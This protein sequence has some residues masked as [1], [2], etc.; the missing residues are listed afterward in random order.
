MFNNQ[1]F[2]ALQLSL[3]SPD[4]IK[5]WSYGEVTKPETINYRTLKPEK[6]GLFDERIFGPTK[7]FECYCG[8]YKRVRYKGVVCDKCGVEVTESRVRRERMGHIELASPA[9]HTWYFKRS[10]SKLSLLLDVAPKDLEAVIYF[11]QS[12]V[13]E[14]DEEKKQAVL[15]KLSADLEGKKK[16]LQKE[17][18][19][20]IQ[21]KNENLNEKIAELQKKGSGEGLELQIEHMRTDTKREVLMLRQENIKDGEK[22]EVSFSA[23]GQKIKEVKPLSLLSENDL[24]ELE[25]WEATDFFKAGMGAEVLEE[26]AKM[27][28]L[29]K[30]IKRGE[31]DLGSRSVLL[32]K[33]TLAK[34]KILQGL[35]RAK[36]NPEWMIIKV[37]PVIPP[38]L[39]P[40]VQLPGG[41]FATSDL[42]DLYRKVI[43]RNNRLKNLLRLGA[44]DVILMNEKRM[45]QEAVDALI[46]G[47]RRPVKRGRKELRSLTEMLSGK[48]GRFRQNL[49]GKRVDY[50]GRSVIVVGPEL[51]VDQ[52]GIPKEMALELAKPFVLREIILGGFAPNLK[53]AKNVLEKRGDEVWDILETVVKDRPVLLNRAPTLHKQNIQAFYPIL[54]GGSAIRLHP[55]VCNGFN[56][57]FDGDAMSVHLPLSEKAVEESKKFM[58]SPNNLLK[59][60]DS[61]PIIDMKN[62][63]TVGLYYL[64]SVD[65]TAKG[66]GHFFQ[67]FNEA[68]IAYQHQG[69]AVRAPITTIFKKE[70]IET[71]V[72]RILLNEILPEKLQFYNEAVTRDKMKMLISSCLKLYSMN[73]AVK[74]TDDLKDLG[75]TF[76]TL[77]GISFAAFDFSV[78]PE[79]DE[80]LK[81]AE[82]MLDKIESNYRRGLLTERERYSQ[83]VALWQETTSKVGEIVQGKIDAS[84]MVG[85]IVN[86]KASRANR[87]T[88]AQVGGM[89]GLM[90][91]SKNRIKETP[92]RTAEIEGSTPFEGFLAALG[93]RKGLIDTALLTA[94]AGYLTR[95]LVDVAHDVLVREVDCKTREGIVISEDKEIE[96]WSLKERI[97]GRVAAEDVVSPKKQSQVLV[98]RN[99][100][101]S[102]ELAD[103]IVKEGV[104]QVRI[105]TLLTCKTRYGV[106]ANCYGWDM[107]RRELIGIGQAVGVIA[108]QSIGEPGT[109]LTLR[110]FHAGGIAK[111]EITQGL[112]RVEELLEARI[113]KEP[114]VLSELS[115]TVE[116][117][118]SGDFRQV[119]VLAEEMVEGKK[120]SE[121]RVYSIPSQVEIRVQ[122]GDLVAAGDTLT[123]GHLDLE[124][125]SRL[126]GLLFAQAYLLKEVQSVYKGQGVTINDKHVEIIL[127]KMSS[128][129]RVIKTGDTSFMPGESADINRFEEEN[130]RV[131][132]EGKESATGHR[133]LTGIT[134]SS[135]N[136]ESWLSASSFIETANVLSAAAIDARPQTDRLL[137]LKENVI[138]G[139][140]IPTDERAILPKP[141]P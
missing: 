85:L 1:E 134:R 19:E 38:D 9:V 135:L 95:R 87:E 70:K 127:R 101:I 42:N 125:I 136:A 96:D 51:R 69:L 21:K 43:N 10:P 52:V 30:E 55:A 113:P 106:C 111:K 45:L 13:L 34:L 49:L 35:R 98:E 25:F 3:A 20:K 94:D 33:K 141:E 77:P 86:S 108:A 27:I 102:E 137:G 56:A 91:D 53:S 140:L 36:I 28:D 123:L 44:P 81:E 83:V 109:Q 4:Q 114:A 84:S 61:Q 126:K 50:S 47:S 132:K 22:L 110:T 63:L 54:I 117:V 23:I 66:A 57:D 62:E 5:K 8:K 65:K 72:G 116:I 92:I 59:L 115:G 107:A 58:L 89:R 40:M 2:N 75:R 48:H 26:A 60:A 80:L 39:R 93:G 79:R 129:I 124:E 104:K 74:L 139:R 128:R 88:L 131:K 16:E 76:A 112:P 67:N 100:L 130:D 29:D 46:E 24:I 97:I 6:D 99:Q 7:D 119:K 32:R 103:Q 118:E 71:T 105:R 120:V 15:A 73:E 17:L 90:V 12:L 41:R 64:T 138:I 133:L 18:D 11:A 68:I 122:N 37:L 78:P 82:A 14:A 121:E 31:K